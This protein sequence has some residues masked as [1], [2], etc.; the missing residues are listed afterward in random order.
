MAT[1]NTTK[2]NKEDKQV[3]AMT[4]KQYGD[5]CKKIDSCWANMK[6]GYIK[7]AGLVAKLKDAKAYEIDGYQN[8]YDMCADKWGMSRGTVS[9]IMQVYK[10][11]GDGNYAL[12]SEKVGDMGMVECLIAIKEE[13]AGNEKAENK[14]DS[15]P[16]SKGIA[17]EAIER[18][19]VE[20]DN[21]D[22]VS[23]TMEM[24]KKPLGKK[25]IAALVKQV[26][27]ELEKHAGAMMD[28]SIEINM[29][30]EREV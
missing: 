21:I 23:V 19:E 5:I 18:S 30:K 22:I 10:H 13:K 16:E 4:S 27:I 7:M 11:F 2:Q 8:I 25:E 20:Q 24:S 17:E 28:L 29:N 6:T 9:N 12:D 15:K 1:K 3:I 14:K 26:K